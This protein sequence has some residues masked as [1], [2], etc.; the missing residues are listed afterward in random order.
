[1]FING[2]KIYQNNGA[3]EKYYEGV[4]TSGSSISWTLKTSFPN[5]GSSSGSVAFSI[6]DKVYI[7]A[8][9]NSRAF[10]LYEPLANKWTQLKD[11]PNEVQQ[12]HNYFVLKDK[13]SYVDESSCWR[14][15]PA[16][17]GWEKLDFPTTATATVFTIADIAY[18]LFED[19][20]FYS[21]SAN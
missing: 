12:T 7:G 6:G 9:F 17:D 10:W 8:G 5:A 16:T 4:V 20:S 21:F 13:G 2:N 1:M 11:V 15:D 19:G 18:F 14:Y 3:S